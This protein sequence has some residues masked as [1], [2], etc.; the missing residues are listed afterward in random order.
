MKSD[1][2]SRLK[3]GVS[4]IAV[5]S[6]LS[7]IAQTS[8]AQEAAAEEEMMFEEVVV[9]G[10]RI[11]RKDIE[12]VSPLAIT[13][14]TEI[15]YSGHT[16]IED[17]MNSM[18]QLEASQTGFLS[19]GATGTATLD[20]RGMGTERTVVLINGRRMQPGG[21]ATN[22]ADINQIPAGLV[23]RVEILTG[24][25]SST[26]GA[27]AVAGVVNFVMDKNFEGVKITAGVSAYQHNNNNA[28]IQG[29]MDD[30]N[31]EYPTGS[32]GL[33]GEQY[34]IDFAIG[35]SF[36]DD[37]GHVTVYGNWRKVKELRQKSRDYSSCA[38]NGSGTSCGGSANA[39]SPNFD[40]YPVDPLTGNTVYAFDRYTQKDFDD[41][42]ITDE[43][44]I[45]ELI[46]GGD[47]FYSYTSEDV[48]YPVPWANDTFAN[49]FDS[50]GADGSLTEFDGSNIYNYAPINHFQRPDERWSGGAFINYEINDHIKPYAEVM[51]MRD[52]TKAQIAESGTFF[53]E[54]YTIS[55]SSPLLSTAQQTDLC[56]T[57]GLAPTDDLAI[58]VGKRNVEGGPRQDNLTH[59]SFRIVVG[60]E[61]EI[62]DSWTYDA[63]F[64]YGST[65]SQSV[66]KNDFYA[67]NIANAL[68]VDLDGD[69][70]LQCASAEARAGGCLPYLVFTPGGVTAEQ[71]N[72]LTATGIATGE[73]AQYIANAYVT[74]DLPLTIPMASDPLQMVLGV[75]YRKETFIRDSDQLFEEGLLLG[76]G[77]ATA[78]VDGQYDVKEIFG[79]AFVP[80][81]QDKEFAE[82]LSM[83]LGL[84]LSDYSSVGSATTYKIGLNWKP[85]NEVKFRGSYNRAV[86]APN[87]LELFVPQTEGLWAG[88]DPCSG[89]TPDLT[90]AQCANTGVSAAQYGNIGESPASQYNSIDG[91]NPDLEAETADTWTFGVVATPLDGLVMS[92]DY[93]DI[94]V[95]GL[96]DSVD[97]E[98]A[99]EQ[100]GLT[101]D[102][103]FC[104]LV[105]RA[106][107]GSLWLGKAGYVTAT[108]QNLGF[109]HQQG[110]DVVVDYEIEGLDGMFNIDL[111]GTYLIKKFTQEI[112]GFAPSEYDCKGAISTQCFPSPKWRHSL[113]VGYISDSF[114]TA[115]VKWRYFGSVTN[116]DPTASELNSEIGAQSYFDLTAN[117]VANENIDITVGVNNIFDKEP[118]L[119]GGDLSTNAN[120]IAGFYD[121]LGRYLHASV[122]ASF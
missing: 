27:D 71:A 73:T 7:M 59:S 122:T 105:N 91:G 18:P 8:Q 108:D 29:L 117:F 107:N 116:L 65:S 121:T 58:Y 48:R 62:S 109:S 11:K 1:F 113:R 77:G 85:I 17:M 96:I 41:G 60:T 21:L 56:G 38:L 61:G 100:C 40:I 76:Q 25:A 13:D 2:S 26:Y 19:N 84:R 80:I 49:R 55:C 35:S 36:D 93:W 45:G 53:D 92:V 30:S 20:L 90:A 28:Y 44:D 66:Y 70:N 115:S 50:L 47:G 15:K 69:G 31:F 16:R 86:R 110:I 75:E 22:A 42:I 3:Y 101:G 83:E 87:S 89:A 4:A 104:D 24:G 97:S 99:V 51:F 64:T 57:Y 118:P 103:V 74:G 39:V 10:S 106:P 72:Y 14:A 32:S 102:A 6:T 81:V 67:P 78:S 119:V 23:E 88:T 43:D 112:P 12:S 34:N 54:E 79:E 46:V 94:K 95:E 33:D 120:A 52:T 111:V 9:T 98:L 114:W 37:K 63:S 5:A 68:D 82:D